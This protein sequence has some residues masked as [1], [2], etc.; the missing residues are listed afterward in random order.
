MRESYAGI[1]A[2]A[3]AFSKTRPRRGAAVERSLAADVADFADGPGC[4][5]AGPER[6]GEGQHDP[7]AALLAGTGIGTWASVE[8]AC[9]ATV[10]VS[11]TIKPKDVGVMQA[12]YA[13]YRRIY[14]ALK[15]I[16]G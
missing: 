12:A 16:Q 8:D 10:R 5:V 13:R 1:A 9:A 6:E 14:P 7:E 4:L 3:T 15:E 2:K 11:E